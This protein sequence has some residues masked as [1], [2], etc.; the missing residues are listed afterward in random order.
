MTYALKR[1]VEHSS[2][3]AAEL[4]HECCHCYQ[5]IEMR[6]GDRSYD[7]VRSDC[8]SPSKEQT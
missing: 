2:C 1:D 8:I 5:G 6:T 3:K 7:V 4:D